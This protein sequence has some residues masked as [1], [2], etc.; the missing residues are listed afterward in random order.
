MQNILVSLAFVIFYQPI[1]NF[2]IIIHNQLPTNTNFGITLIIVGVIVKLL[3][4]PLGNKNSLS[5]EQ[6]HAIDQAVTQI[7]QK[8]ADNPKE[9]KRLIRSILKEN[10]SSLIF[11]YISLVVQGILLLT[12]YF[13]FKTGFENSQFPYLYT[14]VPIPEH[15][16]ISFLQINLL[17]PHIAI[18]I[19]TSMLLFVHRTLIVLSAK[20]NRNTDMALQYILPLISYIVLSQTPAG[21]GVVFLASLTLSVLISIADNLLS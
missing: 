12:L 20:T 7:Q 21:V 11:S 18:S 5:S 16:N 13:I 6:R 2:L 15:L 9:R 3:L 4:I 1:Y 14:A 10:Q 17:N 19:M 8:Y